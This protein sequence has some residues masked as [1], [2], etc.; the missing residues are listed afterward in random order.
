MQKLKPWLR[1]VSTAVTVLMALIV[2]GN[3]YTIAA[4]ALTDKVQP[5]FLGFSSAV[6]ISGSMSDTIE[7]NDYIVCRAQRTYK[8]GDI[9]TYINENDNLI[10]HRI[11]SES[12]AGFITQG[13]A[14][15]TPDRDPVNPESIVGRVVMVIPGIGLFIEF[16]QTPMG[17]AGTA[18][19]GVLLIMLPSVLEK[20]GENEEQS[21]ENDD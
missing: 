10:T 4:R 18:M 2:I 1:I 3:I 9:V 21:E 6:V 20:A 14:N 19:I 16:L 7:V 15:N 5:T 12:D 17:L 13:D 11:V 8:V